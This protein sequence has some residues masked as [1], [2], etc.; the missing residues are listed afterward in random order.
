MTDDRRALVDPALLRSGKGPFDA[1]SVDFGIAGEAQ[2]RA[3]HAASLLCGAAGTQ[4]SSSL[5][6]CRYSP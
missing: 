4:A 3:R 6:I 5:F 1:G 2:R